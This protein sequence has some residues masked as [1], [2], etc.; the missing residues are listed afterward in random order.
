MIFMQTVISEVWALLQS[1]C[2]K[3]LHKWNIVCTVNFDEAG[4]CRSW[5]HLIS[6][7]QCKL[8]VS[9]TAPYDQASAGYEGF[10]EASDLSL[11][12]VHTSLDS[13]DFVACRLAAQSY[14]VYVCRSPSNARSKYL[15]LARSRR[16][17]MLQCWS[18]VDAARELPF[19]SPR[20]EVESAFTDS[21]PKA[22]RLALMR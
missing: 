9:T 16:A 12:V 15:E 8:P 4:D 1:P 22:L 3:L 19:F 5:I 7:D 14:S 18:L 11:F 13:D 10:E 21:P 2:S 6:I 20:R 17:L